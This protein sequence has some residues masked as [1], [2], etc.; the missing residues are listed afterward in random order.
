M[1][2]RMSVLQYL[3]AQSQTAES[4]KN[5]KED[6]RKKGKHKKPCDTTESGSVDAKE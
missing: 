1:G 6:K 4:T 2:H 5:R 3:Y